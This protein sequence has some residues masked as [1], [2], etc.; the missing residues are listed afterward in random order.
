M[1]IG[2]TK[3]VRAFLLECTKPASSAKKLKKHIALKLILSVGLDLA[4]V[5]TDV[6]AMNLAYHSRE[7]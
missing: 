3:K 1:A 4:K 5:I 6:F 7:E 2:L